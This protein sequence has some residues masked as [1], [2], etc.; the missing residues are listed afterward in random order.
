MLNIRRTHSATLY[1]LRCPVIRVTTVAI[2]VARA[3]MNVLLTFD[4]KVFHSATNLINSLFH[5]ITNKSESTSV[6]LVSSDSGQLPV[7]SISTLSTL[8]L[9]VTSQLDNQIIRCTCSNPLILP[10]VQLTD[11]IQILEVHCKFQRNFNYPGN[12]SSYLW[13]NLFEFDKVP[14]S[15]LS[16]R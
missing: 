13:S 16:N 3:S 15:Q 11:Q 14:N 6:E 1:H 10:L 12:H 9:L 7:A 8:H 2:H 4:A 5:Q